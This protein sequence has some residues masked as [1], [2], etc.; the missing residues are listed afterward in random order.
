MEANLNQFRLL[1]VRGEHEANSRRGSCGGRGR[2]PPDGTRGVTCD[3]T[4]SL[5]GGD[6]GS[7]VS[8]RVSSTPDCHRRAGDDS[9][10]SVHNSPLMELAR[11]RP[12]SRQPYHSD[13]GDVEISDDEDEATEADR[14][15]T[16]DT[17]RSLINAL[18]SLER[19]LN[20]QMTKRLRRE[21]TVKG[22]SNEPTVQAG[23][24]ASPLPSK[25]G[26]RGDK[27]EL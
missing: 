10:L 22:A 18:R 23:V 7:N 5:A 16:S 8:L 25:T 26:Q 24:L 2:P 3:G 27:V 11:R 21:L 9:S 13:D 14:R 17:E 15:K 4:S 1:T 12:V 20:D 6:S 19:S